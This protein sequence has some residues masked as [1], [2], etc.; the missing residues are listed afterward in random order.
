M[1]FFSPLLLLGILGR[2]RGWGMRRL[3]LVMRWQAPDNFSKH[4][5]RASTPAE[6]LMWQLVRNRQCCQAK[7]RR[8]HKL[9]PYVLDFFCPEARLVIECDGLPHFTQEGIERD[10]I[11]TQ[12]LNRQ[13]IEVIRFTSH[14]IE[15]ETQRVLFAIDEVL[16]RLLKQD[17]PPHPPTPSPPEE[18]KGS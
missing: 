13:G 3:E 1:R 14:E 5:R 11:R 7:F 8:Q 4:L 15:N 9:G 16:K 12:W 10:R 18:E 17:T 6:Y 2:R